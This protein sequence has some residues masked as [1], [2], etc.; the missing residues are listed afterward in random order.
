M[1]IRR[2][3]QTELSPQKFFNKL[4]WIDNT[5]LRNH[6][7]PYRKEIFRQVLWNFTDEEKTPRYTL[8]L[9]GR[10]KKNWK[11]ADLM[12]AAL[13]RFFIWRSVQGNDTLI[14]ANDLDQAKDDLDLLKKIIEVNPILNDN[15]RVLKREIV[16]ND[17]RGIMK[18]LPSGDVAGSHGKTYLFCGFDEIHG[19]KNWDI[20]E[21]LAPDP[22]RRDALTWITSYASI[23][24]NEGVPLHDM[25]KQGKKGSDPKMFFSWYSA[26][27]CTDE[28]WTQQ[29]DTKEA[30][31]NPS[32][33]SWGNDGYLQQQKVRLPSHKY[34]RLHLNLP[35]APEGAA[36]DANN[37]AESIEIGKKIR[38]YENGIDYFGF[39]DMSGGSA[40]DACLGIAHWDA[41]QQ[42]RV[43]DLL[44][45]QNL[46]FPFDPRMA[47]KRFAQYLKRYYIDTIECDNYGGN[48]FV[49]MF[50]DF[51][52][53]A[54]ICEHPKHKLY[55]EF[56]P[57]LNGGE[58]CLLDAPKCEEQLITLVWRGKK[59]DHQ[60]GDH[61]DW[62]NAAVGAL[63]GCQD[64]DS[65]DMW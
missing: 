46:P 42:K 37:V 26:D 54:L 58:V 39:V 48:T 27:Y 33:T 16:R 18:V 47:V 38:K 53:S 13:Y 19:Y 23:Y 17:G 60:P 34:R 35:G 24:N 59:I 52:I 4:K 65:V 50:Q 49:A 41:V 9:C 11:S 7:E 6:I 14:L 10:A 44:I 30:L 31:A 28:V 1:A 56:E 63:V 2:I 22:T 57:L 43:L 32:S 55:E 15:V 20:F 8:A 29:C 36:Y 5:P 40:D 62:A 61:D 45:N 64:I 21:A 25:T 3:E 12:L 51:G